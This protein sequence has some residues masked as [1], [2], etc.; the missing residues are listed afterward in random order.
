MKVSVG[1]EALSDLTVS[2]QSSMMMMMMQCVVAVVLHDHV[3]AMV[4]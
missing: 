2:V 1:V 3:E 4:A